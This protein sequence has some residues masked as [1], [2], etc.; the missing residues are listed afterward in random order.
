MTKIV[1]FSHGKL[2][3]VI[4]RQDLCM[5]I[6]KSLRVAAGVFS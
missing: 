6:E 1:K 4:N 2:G 5:A 3:A